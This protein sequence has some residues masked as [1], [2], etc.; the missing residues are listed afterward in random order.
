MDHDKPD[1]QELRKKAEI[2]FR[3]RRQAGQA[4]ENRP[5]PPVAIMTAERRS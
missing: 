3:R 5:V 1:E 2:P 4:E